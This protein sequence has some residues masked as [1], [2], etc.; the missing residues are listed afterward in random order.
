MT[1]TEFLLARIDED[2]AIARGATPG[3]WSLDDNECCVY[4]PEVGILAQVAVGGGDGTEVDA[5]HIARHDPAR[6][7]ADCKAK[8]EALIFAKAVQADMERNVPSA[9]TVTVQRTIE[10]NLASIWADHPDYDP[11]WSVR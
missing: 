7:L 3:P 11:E 1:L 9:F 6:V 5:A 10:R 2:E 4:S 8:R